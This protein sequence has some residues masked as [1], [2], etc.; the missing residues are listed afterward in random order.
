MTKRYALIRVDNNC[1]DVFEDSGDIVVAC[2][3]E[4]CNCID[5]DEGVL[6][7][8]TKEQLEKKLQQF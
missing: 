6:Y 7:G 1:P 2:K 4:Y 3:R 5:K 8:D